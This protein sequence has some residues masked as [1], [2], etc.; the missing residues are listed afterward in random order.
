MNNFT[1]LEIEV[2]ETLLR[3]GMLLGLILLIA[4][5]VAAELAL[6]SADRHQTRQPARLRDPQNAKTAELVHQAQNNI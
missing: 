3:L 1:S 5:F 4:F 6:V 2:A